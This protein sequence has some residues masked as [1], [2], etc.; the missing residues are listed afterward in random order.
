MG[1]AFRKLLDSILGNTEMRIVMLG[2]DAA[3]KTTTLYRL[4]PG[5][6]LTT[7]PTVGFNVEAIQYDKVKF[8]VWDVGAR[9]RISPLWRHY[10]VDMDALIYVVDSA[11]RERIGTAKAEFQTIISLPYVLN[12]VILVLANKQDEKGAM[13]PEE[14]GD[15]LG[16]MELKNPKWHIQGSCAISGDGLCEGLDWLACTVKEMKNTR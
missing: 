1:Q 15:G 8:V 13:T 14:V 4:Q 11:D 5:K 16:L 10:F 3:G 2:L 7:I 12:C 6:A 9:E